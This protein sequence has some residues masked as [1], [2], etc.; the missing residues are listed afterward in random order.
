M[1]VT[2]EPAAAVASP[3]AL[4]EDPRRLVLAY[5]MSRFAAGLAAQAAEYAQAA[6]HAAGALRGSLQDLARAKEAELMALAPSAHALGVSTSI[7]DAPVDSPP[8]PW[9]VVLGEAFQAERTLERVGREL[10]AGAWDASIRALA[11]RLTSEIAQ[12]REEVRRLYLRY[13]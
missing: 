11:A 13:T 9:G 4:A 5:L 12:D 1:P 3:D 8:R 6:V 10:A 7:P 2:I